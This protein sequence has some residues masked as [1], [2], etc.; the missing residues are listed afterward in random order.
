MIE[1]IRKYGRS[2]KVLTE[3]VATKDVAAIRSKMISLKQKFEK[4]PD[5]PGADILPILKSAEGRKGLR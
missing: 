2:A 1:A 4:N 3:H 5:A